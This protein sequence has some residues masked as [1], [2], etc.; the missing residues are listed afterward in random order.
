M[1]NFFGPRPGSFGVA[2]VICASGQIGGAN[3]LG[4]ASPLTANTTTTFS[5]P[6]PPFKAR[7]VGMSISTV[8]VPADADGTILARAV[9]Y[10]AASDAQVAV[11]ADIDCEALV[12][13]E[14]TTVGPL[15]TATEAQRTFNGTADSLE[16]NIVNNSGAINT[17]PAGMV[18]TCY[19][20]RLK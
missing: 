10:N 5:L 2:T 15:S 7:F 20:E 9:K 8:T 17:Q 11:S 3:Y 1:Y 14:V 6:T 16:V 19:F 13:R 18:I 12:T 4:G